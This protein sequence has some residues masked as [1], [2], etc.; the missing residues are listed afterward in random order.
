MLKLKKIT[1]AVLALVLAL[2]AL[3]GCRNEVTETAEPTPDVSG[4]PIPQGVDPADGLFSLNCNKD[5]SLNPITTPN[6]NNVLC[7][8][9]MYENVYEV[10]ASFGTSTRII[11]DAQ[12]ADGVFW[13]FTV[14]TSVKFWDGSE[15]SAYDVAY[16]ISRAQRSS[17]LRGRLSG[18]YGAEALSVSQ[19]VITLQWANRQFPSLLTIPVIKDGSVEEFAPLGTGP[20]KPNQAFTRLEVNDLHPKSKDMPLEFIYLR[21]IKEM[22]AALAAFENY[23]TDLVVNDPTGMLNLG[24]GSIND[25]RYYPTTNMHYL[26]FNSESLFFASELARRAMTFV[27]NRESVVNDMMGGA[28]VEAALPM[29]PASPLYNASYSD[30]ISYSVSRSQEEFDAAQVSDFDDDGL[31]E[32]M[33]TGIPMEISINFVVA[34][35]NAQKVAAAQMITDN[36]NALGIT[37]TL[38][39]LTWNDYRNALATGAF[40][41]YYAETMLTADFYPGQLMLEGGALNYG[42]FNSDTLAERINNYMTAE[43]DMRKYH[44]DLM[45]KYITDTAPIVVICFERHQIISHRGVIT[46]MKPSQYSMFQNLEEWTIDLGINE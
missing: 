25:I 42:G 5:Y 16:S 38:N 44:A 36:L 15:L 30:M 46:G 20:Y 27:V 3:T 35:D 40:D 12:S 18:I 23:A 31:R 1:A 37:T 21:E 26:G 43:D 45:N 2:G 9:L 19:F 34:N 39:I 6:A 11:T 14:D 41:M 33:T 22:D 4:P 17:R 10:D 7:T 28:A 24:Y 32:I 29:N 13:V 8:Q